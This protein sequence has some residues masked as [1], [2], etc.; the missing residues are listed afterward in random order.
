MFLYHKVNNFAYN[1]GVVHP[2]IHP[3]SY[4]TCLGANPG[5]VAS[6]WQGRSNDNKD[7]HN[8]HVPLSLFLS[9]N[10]F[11]IS[12]F[13]FIHVYAFALRVSL[14]PCGGAC[15][16][17]LMTSFVCDVALFQ[18][19]ARVIRSHAQQAWQRWASV[20]SG[21]SSPAGPSWW[22]S[23]A[24]TTGRETLTGHLTAGAEQALLA[25]VASG[26]TWFKCQALGREGSDLVVP[27]KMW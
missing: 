11:L 14:V 4:P 1:S 24:K 26:S 18:A 21:S 3:F 20:E 8:I 2:S 5:W 9:H 17:L 6:A 27:Y 15:V 10:L 23:T 22:L 16:V 13:L 25:A 7:E 19:V 12:L